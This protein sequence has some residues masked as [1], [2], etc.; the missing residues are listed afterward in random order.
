M[1]SVAGGIVLDWGESRFPKNK[2]E[3]STKELSWLHKFNIADLDI[4][5][6]RHPLEV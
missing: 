4:A 3:L 1:T 6:S 5:K 2:I